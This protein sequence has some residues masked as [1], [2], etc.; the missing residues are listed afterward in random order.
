MTCE[1]VRIKY[2]NKTAANLPP[3]EESGVVSFDN[4]AK[5][6]TLLKDLGPSPKTKHQSRKIKGITSLSNIYRS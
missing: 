4:S 1:K 5:I 3:E 2:N 6:L